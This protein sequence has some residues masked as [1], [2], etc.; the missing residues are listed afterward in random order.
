MV[1]TSHLKKPP[2]EKRKLE[3]IVIVMTRI[4]EDFPNYLQQEDDWGVCFF[5]FFIYVMDSSI[6]AV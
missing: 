2:N 1:Y 3:T 6:F 5:Y 4:L